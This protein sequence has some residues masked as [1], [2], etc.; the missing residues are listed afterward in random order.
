MISHFHATTAHGLLAKMVYD[1]HWRFDDDAI[2]TAPLAYDPMLFMATR[3]LV[4][5]Y[6]AAVQE[7]EVCVAGLWDAANA[8]ITTRHYEP[9][10]FKEWPERWVFYNNMEISHR[11]LWSSRAYTAWYGYGKPGM[12]ISVWS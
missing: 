10:F 11:A 4:Y 2:L 1:W 6:P 12:M 7:T 9:H 5:G 3:S 8:F